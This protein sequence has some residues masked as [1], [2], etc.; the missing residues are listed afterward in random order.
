MN[1]RE[2]FVSTKISLSTVSCTYSE[3]SGNTDQLGKDIDSRFFS[4]LLLVT[5][6]RTG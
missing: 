4:C 1:D 2:I 6:E 3:E 5:T